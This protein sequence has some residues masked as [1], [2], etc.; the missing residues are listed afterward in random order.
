MKNA[1]KACAFLII[2]PK[3]LY[4]ILLKPKVSFLSKKTL[5]FPFQTETCAW[6]PL[7]VKLVNGYGINVALKPC[8]SAKLLTINL[9]KTCL[10]A[11]V[12]QSV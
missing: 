2:P 3:K 5:V 12:K 6:Q 4:A 1:D 7:P 11:V 9:K 8:F 10:S